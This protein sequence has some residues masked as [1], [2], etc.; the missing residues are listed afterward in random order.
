MYNGASYLVPQIRSILDQLG[1]SDEMVVVDDC[2]QDESVQMIKSFGDSR[3]R[4]IRNDSNLGVLAS[5]EKALRGSAGDILFLSDQDDI[6]RS[7][8]VQRVISVFASNPAIT[9]VV[10]DAQ[11]IDAAGNVTAQSFFKQRGAFSA[12]MLHNLAKNKYL[13]CTMAFRRS[14]LVHFLPIP[15]D[16]PM[17]DIWFGLINN[18]YGKTHYIGQPL[19]A[20]RR[21][22]KNVSPSVGAP[23]VQKLVWRWRLAKNL[24]VH[25]LGY[26]LK[27]HR[28]DES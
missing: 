27:R 6:W 12:D 1:Q 2:S 13:G 9:M 21:H 22:G 28:R 25:V 5:F 3:I 26:A 7:D 8:K 10:S 17:H 23:F 15:R 24:L 4:L 14:M 11:V 20:Y 16:T 18:I 19:I